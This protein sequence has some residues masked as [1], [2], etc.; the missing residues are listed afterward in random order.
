VQLLEP[1]GIAQL[2]PRGARPGWRWW[3]W[4]LRAD[5]GDSWAALA[6]YLLNND[7]TLVDGSGKSPGST[8]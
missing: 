4:P 6:V 3:A 7:F 1:A 5:D 2:R 8:R